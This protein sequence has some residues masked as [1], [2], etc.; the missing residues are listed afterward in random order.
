MLKQM[1]DWF[2]YLKWLLLLIVL[3]FIL[4]YVAPLRD[5][6][7]SA[8][9]QQDEKWAAKVNGA[10]ISIGAFQSYARRLDSMYTQLLGDQYAQQRSMIR[11]GRQAIES[12]VEQELVYQEAQR[13]GISVTPQELADALRRDPSFQENGQFIGVERYRALFGAGHQSIGEFEEQRRRDLVVDK[14]RMMVGD[15][16][17]VSDS[18]VEQEFLKK[19]EKTS[20]DYLVVDP[21]KARAK[22]PSGEAELQRWYDGHKDRYMRGEGRKGIY[23]LFRA[24]DLAAAQNVTDEEVAAAYER[25]KAT[26]YSNGEQ[27]HASHVLFKTDNAAPPDVVA[28]VEKKARDILKRARAGED[29]AALA[30]KYSEDSSAASGGDLGLFGRGQMVKEFEDAAFSLPVGGVSD[31]VRTVYGFHII[32]VTDSRP[33]RIVPLEEARDTLRQELRLEIARPEIL[34]RSTAFARAAAGGKLEAVANSQGLSVQQTGDVRPGDALPGVIASQPV[35]ER[36]LGLTPGGVSDAIPIPSGQVVVQVT[37]TVPP[38]P[39]PFQEARAQVQKDLEEDSARQAVSGALRSAR[40]SGGLRTLARAL[41]VDLKSQSDVARGAVLP[42]LP[43]DPAIEKQI[44]TLS[45]GSIGDP[46]TT[47]AGVV[48]L[49]VKERRDHREELSSQ[50]DSVSDGLLRQ[51]QDRLYRALVKRLR[52][53]SQVQLNQPLV[54]SLDRV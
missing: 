34:K 37:G 21:A 40:G 44:A 36:M 5:S 18:E 28:K 24:A 7:V 41:K 32:K 20:V 8:R 19:N 35:V 26:R 11:I 22:S 54:D 14:F 13:Q 3:V 1:R 53:H 23:V 47:S 31:P 30:R 4:L 52:E 49:S 42:G 33:A 50:R 45:P 39:R 29:F 43:P 12:L 27:R 15:G 10:T 38:A 17:T 6:G 16:V 2:R 48:V 25:Q 46:I 9:R 51:R